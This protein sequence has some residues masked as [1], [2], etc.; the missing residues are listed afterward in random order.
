MCQLK[1]DVLN[2]PVFVPNNSETG[3]MGAARITSASEP[4]LFLE[5]QIE[6]I[7]YQPDLN[8]RRYHDERFSIFQKASLAN[9]EISHLLATQ[10]NQ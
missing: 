1:A 4:N 10:E 5:R 6:G 9:A 7:Y 3:L 8:R 2:R